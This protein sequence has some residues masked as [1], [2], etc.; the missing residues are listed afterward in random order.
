MIKRS[1][2]NFIFTTLYE[3]Y[4]PNR[5]K[6]I[7]RHNKFKN[8]MQQLGFSYIEFNIRWKIPNSKKWYKEQAILLGMPSVQYFTGGYFI[9]KQEIPF[10]SGSVQ[11]GLTKQELLLVAEKLTFEN[12]FLF[13]PDDDN[14]IMYCKG[15][16]K[17]FGYFTP[18]FLF[19]FYNT[20]RGQKIEFLDVGED[21]FGKESFR[22]SMFSNMLMDSRRREFLD[23]LAVD[24]EGALRVFQIDETK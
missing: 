13:K 24:L 17:D 4:S 7:A 16:P 1:C 10:L 19:N 6:N 21:N 22:S 3:G 14:A 23:K 15:I 18:D 11:L 8:I 5:D 2:K 20:I 12:T 9:K